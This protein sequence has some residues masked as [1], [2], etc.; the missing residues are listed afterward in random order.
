MAAFLDWLA[1]LDWTELKLLTEQFAGVSKDALHVLIG[2]FAHLVA[3]GALRRR[4]SSLLPWGAVLCAA[5]ANEWYDLTY[6]TYWHV[7]MW[8]GSVKDVLLTMLI[9]TVLLALSRRA[10]GL[11]VGASYGE[12]KAASPDS[13]SQSDREPA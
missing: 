3:A 11:L 12:A 2:F 7:P 5:V 9:P 4:V 8:P 13:S 10:P 6:E 1:K